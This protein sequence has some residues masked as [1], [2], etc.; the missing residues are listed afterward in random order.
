MTQT[1]TYDRRLLRKPP[2]AVTA[3][4]A[5]WVVLGCAC[6]L[7]LIGL[8]AMDV[9]RPPTEG[10]AL[11]AVAGRQAIFLAIGLVA[12]IGTCAPSY[13]L[14]VPMTWPIM[15]GVVGL[16]VFVLLP[17]VPEAIVTPRNGARRWINVG[18]TDFQPS[19]L[20]KIAYVL[21]IAGYLRYRSNYRTLFGLIPPAGNGRLV[22]A[23][24]AAAGILRPSRRT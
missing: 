23:F 10:Q 14:L 8:H 24:S 12:A 15:M 4:H 11:G 1:T 19:E 3:I 18:F 13:R 17:F 2:S 21:V 6:L 20:A 9:A 5:G 7:S 22:T 16:L